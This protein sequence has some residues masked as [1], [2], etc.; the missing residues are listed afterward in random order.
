VPELER[1]EIGPNKESNGYLEFCAARLK[2]L[3]YLEKDDDLQ[4][5]TSDELKIHSRG[6]Q[7][8]VK[9]K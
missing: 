7:H 3:I 1:F 2:E 8:E 6:Y 9:D 5:T 4:G